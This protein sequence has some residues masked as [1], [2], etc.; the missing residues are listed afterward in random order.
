M[1]AVN[2]TGGPLGIALLGSVLSAGYLAR[3]DRVGLPAAA[4]AAVRQSVFGG[5]AVAHKL[6]SPALLTSVQRAFVSA[7]IALAGLV[8][9]VVFCLRQM[10]RRSHGSRLWTPKVKRSAI[11]AADRRPGCV[12]PTCQRRTRLASAVGVCSAS[13]RPWATGAAASFSP[14]HSWTGMAIDETSNPRGGRRAPQSA[15]QPRSPW[16]E[17]SAVAAARKVAISRL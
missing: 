11:G 1:Q 12:G 8:L 4:V 15:H 7:G 13:H 10:L 5:V 14:C 6:H 3:L 9:T 16:V 17:A 2:K